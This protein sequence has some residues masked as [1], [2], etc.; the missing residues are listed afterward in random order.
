[1]P[2]LDGEWITPKESYTLRYN[3]VTI[4]LYMLIY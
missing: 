3:T 2:S 4:V 1:L